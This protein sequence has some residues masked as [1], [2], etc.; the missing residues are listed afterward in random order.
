MGRKAGRE[1]N[2][3]EAIL[4]AAQKCFLEQGFDGT[5]VRD[6]MKKTGAQMH[7]TVRWDIREHTLTMIEPYICKIVAALLYS[8]ERCELDFLAVS[9]IYR[10]IGLAQKLLE[11]EG[12]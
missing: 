9:P 2:K 11:R 8:K 12:T 3:K 5:S 7:R 10:R 1:T 4:A 6:I